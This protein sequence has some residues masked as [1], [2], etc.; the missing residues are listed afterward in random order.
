MQIRSMYQ[1]FNSDQT[2]DLAQL[3]NVTLV[4]YVSGIIR[5]SKWHIDG[6]WE[7]KVLK[8]ALNLSGRWKTCELFCHNLLLVYV[9]MFLLTLFIYM[10]PYTWIYMHMHM[11]LYTYSRLLPTLYIPSLIC[12]LFYCRH[13]ISYRRRPMQLP[14]SIVCHIF[15]HRRLS[16]NL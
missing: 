13:T 8:L 14:S 4:K 11:Y 10:N 16:A 7:C 1:C 5:H 12:N 6:I 3:K 15:A 9:S 2:N